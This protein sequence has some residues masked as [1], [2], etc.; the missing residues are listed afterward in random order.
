MIRIIT[1]ALILIFQV[2]LFAQSVGVDNGSKSSF[3]NLYDL[4]EMNDYNIGVNSKI[5]GTVF[6][7]E[8][9]NNKSVVYSIFNTYQLDKLNYNMLNDNFSVELSKDSLY[10]LSKEKIDS[11]SIDNLIFVKRKLDNKFAFFE[12]IAKTNSIVLLKK[13]DVSQKEGSFNPLDGKTSPSVLYKEETYY[14]D[15]NGLTKIKP[16]RKTIVPYFKDKANEVNK[17]LK[18]NKISFKKDSDLNRLFEF[19]NSLK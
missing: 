11:V 16:S 10:I 6:L 17:F 2:S 3:E 13:Y 4:R 5:K 18:E 1:T 12:K 8:D 19:Y 14:I 9:W 7:F 15:N